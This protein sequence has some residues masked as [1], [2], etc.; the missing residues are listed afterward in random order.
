M[1][2]RLPDEI[3]LNI[4]NR[5]DSCSKDLRYL[6]LTHSCFHDV[7]H[8]TLICSGFVPVQCIPTYLG[9]LWPHRQWIARIKRVHLVDTNREFA[10]PSMY[11]K[12][13]SLEFIKAMLPSVVETCEVKF[14]DPNDHEIWLLTLLVTLSVA[15]EVTITSSKSEPDP[16]FQI[17]F[18]DYQPPSTKK[19]LMEIASARLEVLN[20]TEYTY[21]AQHFKRFFQSPHFRNLKVL[22]ISG[23][24]IGPHKKNWTRD[25]L[26][27][28]VQIW[29]NCPV[30]HLLRGLETLNIYCDKS[31][32]PWSFLNTLYRDRI[33]SPWKCLVCPPKIR[34][35]FDEPQPR[36]APSTVDVIQGQ[37]IVSV[38]QWQS[39]PLPH[40]I[41]YQQDLPLEILFRKGK[42]CARAGFEPEHYKPGNM[43]ASVAMHRGKNGAATNFLGLLTRP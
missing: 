35:L 8:E 1:M 6:A 3:L 38:I 33:H 12:A 5:L 23:D 42:R 36:L 20:V 2:L 21:T 13:I 39:P 9:L 22:N 26:R 37:R 10:H 41:W 18:N 30:D 4:M 25:W 24:C 43:Y 17:F 29:Y 7:V 40:K 14:R 15:K 16:G 27:C 11:E 19:S 28:L 32:Y 34:L 31:T